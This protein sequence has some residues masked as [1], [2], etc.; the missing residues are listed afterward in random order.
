MLFI[1]QFVEVKPA[2]KV[3][4]TMHSFLSTITT[5]SLQLRNVGWHNGLKQKDRM[6]GEF[7]N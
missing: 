5:F 1:G 6:M 7:L 3:F 4:L 2:L